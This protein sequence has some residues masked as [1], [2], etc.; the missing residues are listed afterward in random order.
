M[1]TVPG[2]AWKGVG[3]WGLA[4]ICEQLVKEAGWL[5]SKAGPEMDSHM[6]RQ[7]N[8]FSV[9]QQLQAASCALGGWFMGSTSH[10][11]SQPALPAWQ[12]CRWCVTGGPWRCHQ[13]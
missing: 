8:P 11:Q 4:G 1:Q 10:G 9:R 13:T 12:W 2:P 7:H 3:R 5:A 6:A